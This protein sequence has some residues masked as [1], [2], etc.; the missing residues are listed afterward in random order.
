MKTC[1]RCGEA[2]SEAGFSKDASRRDG[3]QPY[4]KAC[5][6][7]YK[8]ANRDR[9]SDT[10]GAY[11]AAKPGYQAAWRSANPEKIKT[12]R[13]AW[14][15]ANPGYQASHRAHNRESYITYKYRRRYRELKTGGRLSKG[16]A[17]KLFALQRGKCACCHKSL[18]DGYHMD[19]IMPLALGGP[20]EDTNIQLLCPFCNL[21]KSAKDPVEFMQ[22]RGLL[23]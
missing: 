2:K 12:Q 3:L 4:C 22:Q 6:A 23:L 17:D 10:M 14:L 16:L 11:R 20:N 13:A 19:H 7:V 9:T 8:S 21:S 18:E 5:N 1:A 15:S